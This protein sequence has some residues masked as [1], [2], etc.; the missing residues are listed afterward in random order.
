MYLFKQGKSLSAGAI[1]KKVFEDAGAMSQEFGEK[2]FIS[3]MESEKEEQQ[4]REQAMER[5]K[6]MLAKGILIL[7]SECM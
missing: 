6:R 5:R 3:E 1:R 2:V 7:Q 4:A